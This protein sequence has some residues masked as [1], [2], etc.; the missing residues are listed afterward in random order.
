VAGAGMKYLEQFKEKRFFMFLHFSDPDTK[1]HGFGEGSSEY[2]KALVT[3]DEQAG[4][5]INK[6]KEL[7][8]YGKTAIY[9]T[10]DH[11]FDK[12]KNDHK[13]APEIFLAAT[14]PSI[15]KNGIQSDITPTILKYF[16]L[17]LTKLEPVLP[18]IPLN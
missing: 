3:C 1:G 13:N 7:G 5:V 9:I 2:E 16:C 18:G 14:D 11:G 15:K 17:D 10:A 8:I 6:L 4:R 12:R